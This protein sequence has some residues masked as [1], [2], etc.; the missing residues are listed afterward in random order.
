MISRHTR[1]DWNTYFMDFARLA[2]R[3]SV[4]LRR[5]VGAVIV[6]D[7]MIM[8][9]GYNGV[10][11]GVTHCDQVGCLRDEMD[12]PSGQRH[13]LCRGLHAEQ[14]AII[15]AAYHGVQIR[16]SSMYCTFRPCLICVKMIINAGIERVFFLTDYD[17]PLTGSMAA[18][19]G[20]ELTRLVQAGQGGGK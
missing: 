2:E 3:R 7:R 14:N 8:A 12:V 18:E 9:T 15:Q 19:A 4:C 6:K 11:K 1:P 17:D 16:G 10:P 20:L 5:Q 13:E